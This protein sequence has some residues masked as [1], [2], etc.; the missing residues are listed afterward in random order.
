MRE[1]QR[2]AGKPPGYDGHCLHLKAEEVT[3]RVVKIDREER[4]L[5]LSIKAANYSAD[6][7]AA[8]TTA[9][10]ALNRDS[11]GDMMNLGDLLDAAS[12]KK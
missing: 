2:A 3:A 10:E 1:A 12:D 5:G 6:Q 8:E 4:R 9:F 11:S 7:L